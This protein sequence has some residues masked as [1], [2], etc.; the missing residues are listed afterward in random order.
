MKKYRIIPMVAILFFWSCSESFLELEPQQSVADTEALETLGDFESSITGVYNTITGSEY[1]GRYMMMIPDVMADDVKQNAQANRIED[2]AEHIVRVSDGDA[3][4]LWT[5]MYEGINAANSIINS[6]TQL[7]DAVQDEYNHILGEA[8]ALRA[9]IYFDLVRFFAHHYT[10][11]PEASHLGVP[12]ILEFDVANKPTRNTVKEVY[13]QVIADMKTALTLMNDV[14]R[15]GNSNTLSTISVKALLSRVYLYKED[16]PNAEEMATDVIESGEFELISNANYYDLW[17]TDNSSE[18]IFEISMTEVDNVG[19]QGIAG[20][21]LPEGFGDY[22]PSNDVVS[23]YDSEDARL[24]T[25]EIDPLLTGDFASHR[26]VKYPDINGFDNVKVIRLAEVYLIRAEARAK[27]GTNISGAQDDLDMVH[28]RAVAT[29]ADNADTGQDLEDAIFLERRLELA[30][31]GQRLWDL[32]RNKM[33]IVRTNCT[34]Q[35]CS[36]SYGS[37][38]VILPIPQNETD[39]NPNIEQ[40][41][42][43]GS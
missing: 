30:F 29:A 21:Y 42:G 39:A 36:I 14:S 10:F 17:T 31:E 18:S 3:N 16:W 11:T 20:L 34:S 33:D 1:Y 19:G 43:Y 12:L 8:Y 32:M 13:D 6:E 23:L 2:Y 25:F 35:T 9:Q 5:S 15:T 24:S 40:N 28:Q 37:D 38:T 7:A 22:L 26:M 41:P 4:S 27:I